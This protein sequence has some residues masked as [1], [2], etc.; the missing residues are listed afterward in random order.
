MFTYGFYAIT[1]F[2]QASDISNYKNHLQD[3]KL[4]R[5]TTVQMYNVIE[6]IALKIVFKHTIKL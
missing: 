4:E 3:D 6:Y 2:M 1:R 5:L